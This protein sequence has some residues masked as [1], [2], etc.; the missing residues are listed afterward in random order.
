[1]AYNSNP[2]ILYRSAAQT[3]AAPDGI[4]RPV[5]RLPDQSPIK[6]KAYGFDQDYVNIVLTGANFPPAPRNT[7]S[8]NAAYGLSDANAILTAVT[9]PSNT[10]AG[11]GKWTAS[12]QRVPATWYEASKSPISFRDFPAHSG[13]RPREQ[14]LAGRGTCDEA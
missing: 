3:D 9:E 1:M 13:S 8:N 11:M 5:F 7:S 10:G 12:F 6:F 4:A 2:E 14:F